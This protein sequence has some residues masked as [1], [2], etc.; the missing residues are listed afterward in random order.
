MNL[1]E[2]ARS[3]L[4]AFGYH[5][6]RL[7]MTSWWPTLIL[8]IRHGGG[9]RIL[10]F[11]NTKL[12]L[13]GKLEVADKAVLYLNMPNFFASTENGSIIVGRN[14]KLIANGHFTIG[15]GAF[16]DIK[17]GATL[18]LMGDGYFNRGIHLECR[19]S[20]KIGIGSAIGPNVFIQ[21]C[22]GHQVSGS[23]TSVSP[24]EI[25][26]HVWI[27]AGAKILKGVSIGDGCIVAAGAVVTKSF[28]RN[29]LLA[30]VPAKI[31]KE[32]IEWR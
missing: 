16:I 9:L 28:P 18:T 23:E 20:I 3:K 31:V 32:Q 11:G 14:A 29:C 22:D 8:N 6:R 30:G 24:V 4:A 27:G 26:N 1:Y 25:G 19:E 15:S 21:D 5:P 7:L 2:K 17:D 12:S 10:V 13:R